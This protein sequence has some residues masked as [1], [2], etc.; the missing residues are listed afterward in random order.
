[1]ENNMN[2]NGKFLILALFML[3]IRTIVLWAH[4]L[5]FTLAYHIV[6]IMA[7]K[8]Y[9][10]IHEPGIRICNM[11]DILKYLDRSR[12]YARVGV[13]VGLWKSCAWPLKY[14]WIM[15]VRAGIGPRPTSILPERGLDRNFRVGSKWVFTDV[16]TKTTWTNLY[17]CRDWTRTENFWSFFG[18]QKWSAI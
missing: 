17:F 18:F 4:E 16:G 14:F 5:C 7:N 8:N 13:R 15:K 10:H 3:R 9:M 1:M 12:G 11:H 2:A 6:S